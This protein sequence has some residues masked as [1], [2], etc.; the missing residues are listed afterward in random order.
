M[1]TCRMRTVLRNLF[2]ATMGAAMSGDS[3]IPC[4]P[5]PTAPPHLVFTHREIMRVMFGVMI[6]ILLAALDQTA[7]IPAIPAIARD[8]HARADLSWIVAAYLITATISTPIYGKLSDIYGRRRLLML[9]LSIFIATSVLC[10]TARQ[11]V[12]LIAYRALQGLGGGGLMALTQA[13]IADVVS[14]RERGRYQGYISAVWALASL[15]GP[16]VGGLVAQDL[17]WRWIVWINLPVGALAIGVC[18]DGLRKLA[19]PR[20][21]GR[22]KLD[23]IG[24]L[25]LTA[26]IVALLLALGWGGNTYAWM[27]SPILGL[28]GLGLAL[29]LLLVVQEL[30]AHDPLF[31]PRLFASASFSANLVVSTVASLLLFMCLFAIPLYFQYV[32]G[33]TAAQSGLYVTPFMLANALGNVVG[34]RWARRFGALRAGLRAGTLLLCLGLS[35]LALLPAGAPLW[36][37]ILA[38]TLV[39]PGIGVSLIGSIMNAQ[40]LLRR[41]EIG[42]GT[43]A[44]LLLR[45]VGGASGST[46]AGAIIA[47]GLAMLGRAGHAPGVAAA[48]ALQRGFTLVYATAAA[49]AAIALATTWLMPD[50]PLRESLHVPAA[51]E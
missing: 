2:P 16:L 7:V 23:A 32:R 26:A 25:L 29:L 39:G 49:F 12:Q 43:G 48:A 37:V 33:T 51:I 40:N 44:L 30:R 36:L 41:Q 34:S 20:R 45:S 22:L 10:G 27:S 24:M 9:C 3:G 13:A 18:H 11:L 46:L 4:G 14:P 15:S 38:L 8:L 1:R 17:S 5:G 28:L 42:A 6:C 35:L 31:P 21:D 50:T 19:R 47:S